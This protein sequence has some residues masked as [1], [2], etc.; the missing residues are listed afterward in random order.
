MISSRVGI[1]ASRATSYMLLSVLHVCSVAAND[2]SEM[3]LHDSLHVHVPVDN[4][5]GPEM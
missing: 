3:P 2:V 4:E 1:R 5:R